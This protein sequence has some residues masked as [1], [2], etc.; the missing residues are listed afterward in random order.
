MN[1]RLHLLYKEKNSLYSATSVLNREAFMNIVSE[2]WEE[3]TQPHVLVKAA[4]WFE[5]TKG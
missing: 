4:S 3:F 1:A 5:P 2:V